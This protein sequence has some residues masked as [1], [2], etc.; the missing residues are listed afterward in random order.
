LYIVDKL[1]SNGYTANLCTHGLQGKSLC[2]VREING[3]VG[4]VQVR[5]CNGNC[6]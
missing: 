2:T 4:H 6:M 5:A 1:V 3:H